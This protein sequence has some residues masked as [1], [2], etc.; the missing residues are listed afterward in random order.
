MLFIASLYLFVSCILFQIKQIEDKNEVIFFLWRIIYFDI[1][2]NKTI[3]KLFFDENVNFVIRIF[4]D[5]NWCE[6][7]LFVLVSSQQKCC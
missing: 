1:I 6:T 7:K 4:S 3:L 5:G 2:S